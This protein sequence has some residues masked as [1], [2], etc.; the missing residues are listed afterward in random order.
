MYNSKIIS[1]TFLKVLMTLLNH[2]NKNIYIILILLSINI[3]YKIKI[4]LMY[5]KFSRLQFKNGLRIVFYT[6]II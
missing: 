6:Y 3:R 2:Q 1:Y 5:L 4:E